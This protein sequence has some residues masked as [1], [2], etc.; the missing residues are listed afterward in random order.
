MLYSFILHNKYKM[1]NSIH[2]QLQSL[3]LI[4]DEEI[5]KKKITALADDIK[6]NKAE[7]E[8]D[9][10][11]TTNLQQDLPEHINHLM[12]PE[13]NLQQSIRTGFSNLD[14]LIKGFG[15][16][17]LIVIGAR[18]GMG[19]TQLMVNLALNISEQYPVAYLSLDLA[20]A[21][22]INRI[23]SCKTH[24]SQNQ[25]TS[26]DVSKNA[27]TLLQN[28]L[29]GLKK[30]QL[31]IN[32]KS[33]Y[34]IPSLRNFI[35]KNITENNIKVFFID[36]LQLIGSM[37]NY[38]H[39]LQEISSV[40]SAL[41][42]FARE[43]NITIVISSQLSRAVET[44]GGSKKPMLSD[45]RDSGAIEEEAD[46]VI[47]LWRPEYYNMTQDE[48]GNSYSGYTELIVSKNRTG[49]VGTVGLSVDHNFSHFTNFKEF[50]KDFEFNSER[51]AILDSH[52]ERPL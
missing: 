25:F 44:R 34:H 51:K 19:K 23:L 7:D 41:K 32:D 49:K 14:D 27:T 26:G 30:N 21:A 15:A 37:T 3:L 2:S 1:Q 33:I 35:E 45:L 24:L 17:E 4:P 16:G 6:F 22:L 11:Y 38:K 42:N 10:K 9:F 39:R 5:L 29:E 36:Y 18:P 52:S 47:F 48:M 43:Y 31:F 40:C 8:T 20:K 13:K 12:D 28:A 50:K 46:K